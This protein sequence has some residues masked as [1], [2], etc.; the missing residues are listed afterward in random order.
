M[1]VVL[2]KF[3]FSCIALAIYAC[4]SL[5]GIFFGGLVYFT[6]GIVGSAKLRRDREKANQSAI[7]ILQNSKGQPDSAMLEDKNK[8]V[9][10][11]PLHNAIAQNYN[12][13]ENQ[14]YVRMRKYIQDKYDKQKQEY[15]T[16]LDAQKDKGLTRE[17]KR[18]IKQ[19]L[20]E[21]DKE[22]RQSEI[23]IKIYKYK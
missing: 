12:S 8:G 9:I 11:A 1:M 5:L 7:G 3:I 16:L 13:Y 17:Y 22:L 14:K 6:F 23:D 2:I 18:Y 10:S 21:L 19:R 4:V 20:K 15:I